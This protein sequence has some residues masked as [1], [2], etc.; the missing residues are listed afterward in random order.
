MVNSNAVSI[1]QYIEY[2][3]LTENLEIIVEF[4]KVQ[5]W[6]DLREGADGNADGYDDPM[7]FIL[8]EFKGSGTKTNP[9]LISKEADLLTLAYNVNVKGINY[10]GVVFKS[11][12]KNMILNFNGYYFTPIG[13]ET[14]NFEGIILGDNLTIRNINIVGGSN[15][16]LFRTL[17]SNAEIKAINLYGQISGNN[18]VGSIAGTNNGTIVG[19]SNNMTITSLNRKLDT[20][21]IVGGLVALNNAT[22]SRS[23]NTGKITSTATKVAGIAAVNNYRIENVYNEARVYANF[24]HENLIVAGLVAVNNS[25]VGFGYNNSNVSATETEATIIGTSLNAENVY[26]NANL[27]TSTS[28]LG[29]AKTRDELINKENEIYANW[30][31]ET[32]WYFE[33]YKNALPKLNIVYEYRGSLTINVEFTE[34]FKET[35]KMILVDVTNLNSLYSIALSE[36]RN[37]VTINELSLGT[38]KLH[39]YSLFGTA[40]NLDKTE[41]I[42]EEGINNITLLIRVSKTITNGYHCGLIV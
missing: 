18:L 15:I 34:D 9:Y 24:K 19:V 25:Y 29:E 12:E 10:K 6:L 4:S 8:S 20:N 42:F 31:F 3:N 40:I 17:G 22:I 30:N 21:N 2:K 5:T 7:R 26:Y 16:G 1:S 35:E 38:Y 14:V 36:Q 11:N 23:Y 27:I 37:T 33:E 28:V 13:T 32:I 39:I 41:I